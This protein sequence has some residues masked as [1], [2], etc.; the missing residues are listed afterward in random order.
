MRVEKQNSFKMTGAVREIWETGDY[1]YAYV[2]N[3]NGKRLGL[4]VAIPKK[5]AVYIGWSFCSPK[6]NGFNL[7]RGLD[8]AISR[9]VNSLTMYDF[10]DLP[11]WVK[12]ER[13]TFMKEFVE[14]LVVRAARMWFDPKPKRK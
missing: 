9:A 3:N 6:E 10:A 8:E 4:V 14:P 1:C 7:V 5:G 2:K 13:R 12:K 11:S